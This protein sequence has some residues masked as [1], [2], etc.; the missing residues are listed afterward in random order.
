[1]MKTS[2]WFKY[3]ILI[4]PLFFVYTSSIAQSNLYPLNQEDFDDQKIHFGINVGFVRSHYNILHS[5]EFLRFDSINVVESI[6]SSGLNIAGLV[7]VKLSN[8]F[9]LRTYPLNLILTEKTLIYNLSK[10]NIALGEDSSTIKK[11][12]GV[13]LALPVE[14]KFNSDRINNFRV[15]MLTGMR[16]EYDL[17]SNSGKKNNNDLVTLKKVDYAIEGAIGFHFYLPMVVLTP[18]IKLSYGLRNVLSK[19]TS[20]KYSNVISGVQSRSIIFTLTIE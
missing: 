18:E 8:N 12:S 14:L 10:P 5:P 2:I 9:S 11:V 6:N 13:S 4:L 1:M 20:L 16:V 3:C 17:A 19:E 7:N 15:Y